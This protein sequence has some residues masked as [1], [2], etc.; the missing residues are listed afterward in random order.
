MGLPSQWVDRIF[1]RLT[2]SYGVE[3]SGKY[4]GLAP[5]DVKTAWAE[6]LAG[7]ERVPEVIAHVLGNLPDKAPNAPA[8]RNLCMSAPRKADALRIDAPKADPERVAAELAKLNVAK[9]AVSRVDH[10]A[11]ARAHIARHE[12]GERVRPIAL[13][14]ARE[15]LK[16]TA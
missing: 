6:E 12:A 8:F 11:W 4:K 15:A 1:D 10:K 13:Q 7:F 5:A 3:F 2:A 9:Q 16:A 14:Y